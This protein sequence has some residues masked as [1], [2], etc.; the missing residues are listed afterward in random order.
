MKFVIITHAI[1]KL[2]KQGIFTYE[3]YVREMNLWLKY[4]DAV[5]IVA[6]ISSKKVSTIESAYA[7]KK[8]EAIQLNPIPSFNITS[9]KNS[10]KTLFKLPLICYQIFKAMYWAD[11]IHLRC[12]GNV[13]ML[14]CLVQIVFP[15]KPKTIKYAG[16]WDPKSKQ[17]LSY[18]I[19]KWLLSNSFLTRNCKVLVYGEWPNQPKNIV[20]FFTASYSETELEEIA[21]KT[22]LKNKEIALLHTPRNFGK[23]DYSIVEEKSDTQKLYLIYVGGLTIGKQPLVSVQVAEQLKAMGYA[24]QLDIYGDGEERTKLENYIATKQLQQEVI[25]HGNTAKDMVKKA[26]QK[27]HF[28]VFIS[29][30]EGWP[31]VVAEA[32]FWGCVPITSNVSC[33]PYMLGEGSRGTIVAPNVNEICIVIKRYLTTIEM[34]KMHSKNAL[35]WSRNFTLEKFE[36]GIASLCSQ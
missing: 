5:N 24:V 1:H 28:L 34:Y 19:Q 16:N 18:R 25:L 31:K 4:V 21:S 36:Q 26:Y 17:P 7:F 9:F 14:G 29:K 11:H 22:L 2:T 27:A 6:P 20:P 12:P 23:L 35:E 8:M 15:T 30:S 10:L 13:G 33:I 32:M 3:P